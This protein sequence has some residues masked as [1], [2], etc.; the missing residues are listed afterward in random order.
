MAD[1]AWIEE[2]IA[3]KKAEI[4]QIDQTILRILRTAQQ[5]SRDDG[6]GRVMKQE[7]EI[8]SL[9]LQRQQLEAEIPGLEAQ[10]CG[11]STTHVIPGF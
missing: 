4:L 6:Q 8:A 1:A 3:A 7:A 9:R 5:Y 11:G 10:L 2:R